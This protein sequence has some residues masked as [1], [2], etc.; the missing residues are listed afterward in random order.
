MCSKIYQTFCGLCCAYK[1]Q[2]IEFQEHGK[3]SR[4]LSPAVWGFVVLRCHQG[5]TRAELLP[6]RRPAI[7]EGACS[8][9][10]DSVLSSEGAVQE[11]VLFPKL[12]AASRLLSKSSKVQF[13]TLIHNHLSA[14]CK[15]LQFKLCFSPKQRY[16]SVQE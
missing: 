8:T 15:H 11:L 10:R 3:F 13:Q 6:K 7:A 4:C 14:D 1:R 2:E 5:T 9:C 12:V 16:Y